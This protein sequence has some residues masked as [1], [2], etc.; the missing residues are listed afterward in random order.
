MWS[1]QTV[2][3]IGGGPSLKKFDWT[4]I[5]SQ[6]IIGV[7][8]AYTLGDWVDICYFSDFGWFRVHRDRHVKKTANMSGRNISIDH[9]GLSCF[10]GMIVTNAEETI[11]IPW[12]NTMRRGGCGLISTTLSTLPCNSSS[13]GAAVALAVM[14]GASTVILLGFDMKLGE[15]GSANWHPNIKNK[16][17]PNIYNRS[18][19]PAFDR[20]AQDAETLGVKILNANP[21]SELTVFPRVS[22][23]TVMETI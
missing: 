2:F 5:R 20:I 17:N 21:N 15:D 18:F 12:V 19:I 11:S 10:K 8:D 7:N 3:V 1:G 4:T 16:P 6:R 9:S 13:G 14:L 22:M 23:S